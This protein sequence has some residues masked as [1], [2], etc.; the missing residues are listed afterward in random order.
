[1]VR[2]ST[3][4]HRLPRLFEGGESSSTF[5]MMHQLVIALMMLH[6]SNA[7]N[8]SINNSSSNSISSIY[9]SST[10]RGKQGWHRTW[11]QQA[12]VRAATATVSVMT[13]TMVHQLKRSSKVFAYNTAQCSL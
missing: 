3:G 12:A 11:K 7:I 10:I 4:V 13:V 9:S 6:N 2:Y 5:F 1:M 8:N